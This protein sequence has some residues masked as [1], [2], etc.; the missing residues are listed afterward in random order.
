MAGT[1]EFRLRTKPVRTRLR[2]NRALAESPVAEAMPSSLFGA[3]GRPVTVRSLSG[4]CPSHPLRYQF[5]SP[6][7]ILTP[8]SDSA[9]WAADVSRQPGVVHRLFTLGRSSLHL[10]HLRSIK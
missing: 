6:F 8:R 3:N 1:R 9:T 7:P 4:R 2:R 5:W 10:G